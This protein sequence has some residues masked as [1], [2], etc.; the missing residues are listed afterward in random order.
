MMAGVDHL[1]DY[2]AGNGLSAGNW[3]TA[4]ETGDFSQEH[5]CLSLEDSV[6]KDISKTLEERNMHFRFKAVEEV[7]APLIYKVEGYI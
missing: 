6:K 1:Q 5:P 3:F 4:E 7:M 2:A